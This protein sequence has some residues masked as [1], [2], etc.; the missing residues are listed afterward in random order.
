M[1]RQSVSRKVGLQRHRRPAAHRPLCGAGRVRE[2]S[3][4]EQAIAH[5]S[6]HEGMTDFFVWESTDKFGAKQWHASVKIDTRSCFVA[7][8]DD[9]ITTLLAALAGAYAERDKR[10]GPI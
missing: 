8:G 1:G 9:P 4:L 6:Q 5:M 2:V 3:Q 10:K 7:K